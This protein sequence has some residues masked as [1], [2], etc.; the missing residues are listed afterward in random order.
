MRSLLLF[1]M[2]LASTMQTTSFFSLYVLNIAG[3]GGMAV[4]ALLMSRRLDLHACLFALVSAALMV[5]FTTLQ[6]SS[7]I[8][9]DALVSRTLSRLVL[10]L[11]WTFSAVMLYGMVADMRTEALVRVLGAVIVV[12]SGFV[13]FQVFSHQV[14]GRFVDYSLLT[15]GI[16]SRSYF[17]NY[18]PSGFAPEPA[19]YCAFMAGLIVLR[20]VYRRAFDLVIWLGLAS[21]ALT[22]STVGILLLIMVSAFYVV[23]LQRSNYKFIFLGVLLMVFIALFWS[24]LSTRLA[25]FLAGADTSNRL[26]L[27]ALSALFS[28]PQKIV[29]GFGVVGRD[30]PS[31]PGYYEALKDLTIFG[32]MYTVFGIFGGTLMLALAALLWV[33]SGLPFRY[34][35]FLLLP[36]MKLSTPAYSFFYLYL[37][38]FYEM[39]NHPERL[40]ASSGGGEQDDKRPA[41]HTPAT[42][43]P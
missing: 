6:I 10:D 3:L 1:A 38:M 41:A 40:A 33:R 32:S 26:K 21:M 27:E 19:I 18:R 2:L 29:Q 11:F 23:F 43:A 16:P 34:K 20:L 39:L 12:C 13:F 15:G 42:A 36:V 7:L 31:L 37:I 8:Q 28:D 9:P 17:G 4:A 22:A 35:V 30:D 5:F 14:L 25:E 24:E